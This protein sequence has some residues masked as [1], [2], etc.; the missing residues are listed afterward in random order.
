LVIVA[1]AAAPVPSD[2]QL[3]STVDELRAAI[4]SASAGQTIVMKDGTW[5]DVTIDIT[6]VGGTAAAPIRIR[7]QTPG[8]VRL[9][10]ASRFKISAPFI[11]IDGL[12]FVDSGMTGDAGI[13]EF[14]A[15]HGR[16]TE[17]SIVDES[18]RQPGEGAGYPWVAFY[19]SD[20]R[21]DHS[22]FRGK[23]NPNPVITNRGAGFRRNQVDASYFKQVPHLDK[24]GRE[25]I[26]IVGY[27]SSEEMG[28]DGAFFVVERNLFEEA[29]GE[30]M[31]IISIKSNR[32][33]VRFNTFRKTKGGITNRSGN[34]NTIE[35]NIIL[36]EKEPGSYGIRVTGHQQTVA[37]NY[38]ADVDGSGLLLVA[39]EYIEKPLTPQYE[40]IARRGTP[41]GRVPRYAQVTDGMFAHNTLVNCG[42]AA[43]EVGSAYRAG[44][45]QHQRVLL[46]ERN[47]IVD[48]VIRQ[49]NGAATVLITEAD[50]TAP[51]DTLQFAS[52]T[53]ANNGASAGA[54]EAPRP[55]TPED[56]GPSWMHARQPSQKTPSANAAAR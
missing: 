32:N 35:H 44:W 21:V 27:G 25:I 34:F 39:G 10:G 16:L 17:S 8:A 36:G 23:A 55:L 30:G 46:P 47:R 9:T 15:D 45:P 3:V 40:P 13:I 5:S 54:L 37:N 56:V 49:S 33:I 2:G 19:G 14:R 11:V 51:L 42:A 41:L 50:R 52:N 4:A 7:A 24:N 26:Q 53:Y 1:A 6:G 22:F 43:I 31:E 18:Q 48:N 12:T 28:D 20:N 38:V 29:H